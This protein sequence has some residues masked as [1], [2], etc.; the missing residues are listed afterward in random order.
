MLMNARKCEKAKF[1]ENSTSSVN[2]DPDQREGAHREGERKT[3]VLLGLP[4]GP[5][6][7]EP[8]PHGLKWEV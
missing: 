4:G 1:D 6:R 2:A 8:I 7:V 5:L 3:S